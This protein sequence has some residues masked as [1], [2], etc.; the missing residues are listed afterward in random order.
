MEIEV[1]EQLAREIPYRKSVSRV[2]IEKTFIFWKS[3]PVHSFSVDTTVFC[4]IA[5]HNRLRKG[6][7]LLEILLRKIS[8]HKAVDFTEKFLSV[9]SHKESGNIELQDIRIFRIVIRTSTK[10]LGNALY[11]VLRSLSRTSTVGIMDKGLLKKWLD[12]TSNE[13]MYNPISEMGSEYLAF[14]GV[15]DNERTTWMRSVYS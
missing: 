4:N 14:H 12:F 11:S 7:I 13:V 6:I 10:K 2:T 3:H 8:V 9:D 1:R 5:F 15:S